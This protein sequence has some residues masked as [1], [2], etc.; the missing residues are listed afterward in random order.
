MKKTRSELKLQINRETLRN[1]EQP[2]LR[3]VLG[4]ATANTC[5][6]SCYATACPSLGC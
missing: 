1:L 6:K 3:E 2:D 5:Y 4:G